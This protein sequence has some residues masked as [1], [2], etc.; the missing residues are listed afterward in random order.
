LDQPVLDT[1]QAHPE[2]P[3]PLGAILQTAGTFLLSTVAILATAFAEER[4][5]AL[6]GPS[7]R[8]FSG[9]ERSV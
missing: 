7:G 2:T 9:I 6:E 4:L 5:A 3:L 1:Q 8:G